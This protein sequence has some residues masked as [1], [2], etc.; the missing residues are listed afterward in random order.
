MPT[1][2]NRRQPEN[3]G[4]DRTGIV[5]VFILP[6]VALTILALLATY[7]PMASVWISEAAQAEFVGATGGSAIPDLEAGPHTALLRA[8][9]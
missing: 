9:K 5:G 1:T 3:D 7:S 6:F 4:H 2:L 8:A